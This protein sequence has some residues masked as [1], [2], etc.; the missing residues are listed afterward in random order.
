MTVKTPMAALVQYA[1][2]VAGIG[3][4]LWIIISGLVVEPSAKLIEAINRSNARL[5][6]LLGRPATA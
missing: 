2:L 4:G 1:M 3:I 5:L 6:R